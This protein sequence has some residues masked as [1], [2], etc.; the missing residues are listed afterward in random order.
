MASYS[1]GY[2][3]H[4]HSSGN[5]R[6]RGQRGRGQRGR[7]QRGQGHHGHDRG[8]GRGRGQ[9]NS[10]GRN[11]RGQSR[12]HG[13]RGGQSH[14]PG[15]T[16]KGVLFK[17][18][19]IPTA[20]DMQLFLADCA[21]QDAFDLLHNLSSPEGVSSLRSISR[22]LD[23]SNWDLV[24]NGLQPFLDVL[25]DPSACMGAA[26]RCF[27][28]VIGALRTAPGGIE[29]LLGMTMQRSY[30]GAQHYYGGQTSHPDAQMAAWVA[31]LVT[32]LI[33]C[34]QVALDG[35]AELGV[36]KVH[37]IAGMA[38]FVEFV[39]VNFPTHHPTLQAMMA[40]PDTAVAFAPAIVSHRHMS[41]VPTLDDI[42]QADIES[43]LRRPPFTE[44]LED[45]L[46]GQF[47]L[48]RADLLES[49]KS[50]RE[51]FE[52][53]PLTVLYN[54]APVDLGVQQV[55]SE[56]D[57]T[58]HFDLHKHHRYHR[59][60][61]KQE[62]KEFWERSNIVAKGSLVMLCEEGQPRYL[63]TVSTKETDELTKGHLGLSFVRADLDVIL[64]ELRYNEKQ[65][66]GQGFP[67]YTLH[68]VCSNFFAIRPV[69]AKLKSLSK[70]PFLDE[71][72]AKSRGAGMLSRAAS[73]LR[74]VVG[75]Y[76]EPTEAVEKIKPKIATSRRA[77]AELQRIEESV[78]L[79]RRQA[80]ALRSIFQPE[81]IV[82]VQGPPGCGKTFIGL[83]MARIYLAKGLKLMLCCYTNHA[84]DS[85]LLELLDMMPQLNVSDVV[86]IGGRSREERLGP[87]ALHEQRH[88]QGEFS[89]A[90]KKEYG[91]AKERQTALKISIPK[92]KKRLSMKVGV[93]WWSTI[94]EYLLTS[95]SKCEILVA[96]TVPQQSGASEGFSLVGEDGKAL[97]DDYLWRRWFGGKDAGVC[98]A[99]SPAFGSGIWRMKQAER[100]HLVTSWQDEMRAPIR[101]EIAE[102]L[103]ELSE[104]NTVIHSLKE[105]DSH[106]VLGKAKIIACTTWGAANY[107]ELLAAQ[108]VD[109][110]I[111]E[112]AGEILEQHILT[113]L[114]PG[115]D[116]LVLIGDH[117]QL[118]PKV[119]SYTLQ[120]ESGRG[121]DLNVS[122]F[123]R[124]VLGDH[125]CT[126]LQTQHRMRP[127]ISALI[128]GTMYPDLKDAA[129]VAGRPDVKGFDCNLM[130]VNHKHVEERQ[131]Q[132]G[133]KLSSKT[134]I[135]EAEMV[136]ATVKYLLQQGY[137]TSEM[138]VLTPYLGQLTELRRQL[139]NDG[140]LGVI[141]D[142]RDQAD[143]FQSGLVLEHIEKQEKSIRVA[144]VDNYQGEE[145]ELVLVSLV[146]SND[147]G[148]IGFCKE[149]ERVNVMLSRARRGM[150]L[151]GNLECFLQ[152]RAK[153]GR[154][155]WTKLAGL[156]RVNGRIY[157]GVVTRCEVHRERALCTTPA[158]FKAKCPAG[159]CLIECN[160]VL[161]CGH[162]CQLCCHPGLSH[163]S[164]VCK[165]RQ[166]VL[167][168]E[169]EH[170]LRFPCGQDKPPQC[171][172]CTKIKRAKE[173]V[174]RK[175]KELQEQEAKAAA[176]LKTK[177]L[178]LE[179][180]QLER[181]AKLLKKQ[182][183]RQL[184]AKL[185]KLEKEHE[186]EL[187][188]LEAELAKQRQTIAK[189]VD[190]KRAQQLKREQE[191]RKQAQ[192]RRDELQREMQLQ[193]QEE[194][195]RFKR[196]MQ[197]EANQTAKLAR[198]HRQKAE[199]ERARLEELRATSAKAEAT[200]R[201]ELQEIEANSVAKLR[202][203]QQEEKRK[204]QAA[205]A[206]H[207]AQ[208]QQA[209]ADPGAQDVQ[210]SRCGQTRKAIDCIPCQHQHYTCTRCFEQLVKTVISRGD[211]R[212]LKLHCSQRA[213]NYSFPE[214]SV[215]LYVS[216]AIGEAY[217][218]L[219]TEGVA[220]Q[221]RAE[222]NLKHLKAAQAL[223]AGWVHRDGSPWTHFTP[224]DPTGPELVEATPDEFMMCSRLFRNGKMA[225]QRLKRVERV[226]NPGLWMKYR[227]AGEAME[228]QGHD[229]N[230]MLL[231][232][233]TGKFPPAE[234]A[235]TT[236]ID[237]R[238]SREGMFGRGAYFAERSEYSAQNRYVY[239]NARGEK[240]MIVAKVAA[241]VVQS[242]HQSNPSIIKPAEGYHSV[243]GYVLDPDYY[244]IIVYEVSQSYPAYILT[245]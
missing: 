171:T 152:S 242:L 159:G 72:L 85:F 147:D 37:G 155:L 1:G 12:G 148:S 191:A 199:E 177:R 23:P 83:L 239:T 176:E 62:K 25:L 104:L 158:D 195:A 198:A 151:F 108:Q 36:Q 42:L 55:R 133:A 122:L 24:F 221:T 99:Q 149:P 20:S 106:R 165:L 80:K 223:P 128:R 34:Q 118:R 117:Q 53:R 52:H 234:L 140:E 143:V 88:K 236:G 64:R 57:V 82:L 40:D 181:K 166:I 160:A 190:A 65:I 91:K 126:K 45:L 211:H 96:L 67:V 150:F 174:H 9:G 107:S 170:W 58:F 59:L 125:P 208:A 180:Q 215:P 179:K 56:A 38:E 119:E 243:R 26:K 101:D 33:A 232:H 50:Q 182:S 41:I 105:S 120:K 44:S 70:L 78:K 154:E 145:S 10:Q 144:T 227:K 196:V 244:A 184:E 63:A 109:V 75:F 222:Q 206:Q 224:G 112:E 89:Q 74:G 114:Q 97:K 142:G 233:G 31:T 216:Q 178:E 188:A 136:V 98:K 139:A 18:Q 14:Q 6:G 103:A 157:D 3:L 197:L 21:T 15:Q 238:H 60:K 7:G 94:Q 102:G 225:S 218:K 87:Y 93:E 185:V 217:L 240:Q 192:Q 135:K 241:G 124:L 84:L 46:D 19:A 121:Y 29:A 86:R 127:T 39:E 43:Q 172:L 228:Q 189:Q 95:A 201:A 175:E 187:S 8:R 35:D 49:A 156:L 164:V 161:P 11:H 79:D 229:K 219:V 30:H 132:D 27:N 153:K 209:R 61:S 205:Q 183:P 100:R 81:R 186:Q 203:Q 48:L 163:D 173:E 237:F 54:V 204:Q 167:C 200:R 230:E 115:M 92:L 169:G 194:E 111:A 123:E 162:T 4:Q 73:I 129:K 116:Q 146:R 235:R 28:E 68:T 113:A 130:F 5:G 76:N 110:M 214:A 2:N 47:K 134:N 220:A 69:L 202:R 207:A 193:L 71:L 13:H 168:D 213:C 245:Y 22:F 51:A 17:K 210:C 226:Q 77:A 137:S 90:Q 66:W 32:F 16:F 231:F 141:L 131:D 212:S 138:V